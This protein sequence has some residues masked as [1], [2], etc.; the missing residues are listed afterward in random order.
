MIYILHLTNYILYNIMKQR[1]DYMYV[2]ISL[3]LRISAVDF[4][5]VGLIF[6]YSEFGKKIIFY[7]LLN[8]FCFMSNF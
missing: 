3:Y 6:L 7:D 8:G 4:N 2:R 5:R 1:N